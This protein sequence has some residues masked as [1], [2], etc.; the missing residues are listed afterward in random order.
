MASNNDSNKTAQQ[1]IGEKKKGT[2]YREFPG[3][4]VDKRL[5]DIER[6]ARQGIDNAKKAKKL[7]TDKRFD[8]DDNRK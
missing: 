4:Y 5:V 8:K 7:L 1:I 6:D 2:I 3:E